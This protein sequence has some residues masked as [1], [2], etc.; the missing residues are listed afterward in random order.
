ML[1]GLSPRATRLPLTPQHSRLARLASEI[2]DVKHRALW[3]PTGW[4][5]AP[6]Y[7]TSHHP[8]LSRLTHSCPHTASLSPFKLKK[9]KTK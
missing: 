2:S 6:S 1:L 8:T 4:V 5:T 7:L 9:I 3:L